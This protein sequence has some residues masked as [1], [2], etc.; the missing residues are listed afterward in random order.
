MVIWLTPLTPQLSMWFMYDPLFTYNIPKN[1][2]I[3]VKEEFHVAPKKKGKSL[4]PSRLLQ[5]VQ[6]ITLAWIQSKILDTQ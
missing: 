2:S 6:E 3:P 1:W 4:M 5:S